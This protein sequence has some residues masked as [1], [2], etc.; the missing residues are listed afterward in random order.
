MLTL[1]N[2]IG[3]NNSDTTIRVICLD[4][5][6][7]IAK[8]RHS[9]NGVGPKMIINWPQYRTRKDAYFLLLR[10]IR[11]GTI[12]N[13]DGPI[14]KIRHRF[15]LFLW[16]LLNLHQ[17]IQVLSPGPKTLKESRLKKEPI[18]ERSVVAKPCRC[19]LF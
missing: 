9:L 17:N 2:R 12:K 10:N 16:V 8:F 15:P 6:D 13:S 4:A 14:Q 11:A 1:T 3:A 5:Q 19:I 7:N 18:S